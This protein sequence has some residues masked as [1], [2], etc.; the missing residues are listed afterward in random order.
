M[1]SLGDKRANRHQG[2]HHMIDPHPQGQSLT[3]SDSKRITVIIV[4]PPPPE[5]SKLLLKL[6]LK[7]VKI[8]IFP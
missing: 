6:R 3:K 8:T 7:C 5:T 4:N 2:P 1:G